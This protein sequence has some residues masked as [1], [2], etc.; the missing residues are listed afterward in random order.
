ML[1]F[2]YKNSPNFSHINVKF[3]QLKKFAKNRRPIFIRNNSP[4]LK[5]SPNR[6]KI[7]QSVK[8]RPIGEKSP[9]LVTLSIDF[10]VFYRE[11]RF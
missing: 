6:W 9:N 8:N 1:I 4:G 3:G 5:I 10:A 7:A 11:C 2:F